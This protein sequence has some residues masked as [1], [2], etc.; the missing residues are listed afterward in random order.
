M[1]TSFS[2]NFFLYKERKAHDY[3]WKRNI[4]SS[5]VICWFRK[6]YLFCLQRKQLDIAKG[7]K[8]SSSFL[9][10]A[11][12]HSWHRI[13]TT[14]FIK[15]L[16][17]FVILIMA[18]ACNTC[19]FMKYVYFPSLRNAFWNSN[20][21]LHFYLTGVYYTPLNIYTAMPKYKCRVIIY[22]QLL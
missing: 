10:S 20:T 14:D 19:M 12:V 16:F 9:H 13:T 21:V 2:F 4:F 6:M 1:G 8:W 7:G 3:F 11:L 5:S 17:L 22:I 18:N 15:W